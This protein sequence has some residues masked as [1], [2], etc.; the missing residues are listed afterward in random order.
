MIARLKGRHQP[1]LPGQPQPPP[2]R[3]QDD[4]RFAAE[5]EQCGNAMRGV[6][7]SL[8]GKRKGICM[9]RKWRLL[10]AIPAVA[11]LALTMGASAASAAPAHQVSPVRMVSSLADIPSAGTAKMVGG[12]LVLPAQTAADCAPSY[13]VGSSADLYLTAEGLN[14]VVEATSGQAD[15]W[16]YPSVGTW[17]NIVYTGSGRCL[18]ENADLA[19]V[20]MQNCGGDVSWQEWYPQRQP[21]GSYVYDNLWTLDNYGT[22]TLCHCALAT[23]TLTSGTYVYATGNYIDQWTEWYR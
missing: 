12:K 6:Q 8:L 10:V 13:I 5:R 9:I 17:G 3:P 14:D 21:N 15:C 22:S 23:N 19:R 7:R 16:T 1:G 18:A 20:V 4:P 11:G 2:S